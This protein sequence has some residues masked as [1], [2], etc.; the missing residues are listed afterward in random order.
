[1]KKVLFAVLAVTLAGVAPALAQDKPIHVNLGGGVTMPLSDVKDRFGTG[2]HFNIGVVFEP[3][4][5]FGLGVEYSFNRLAGEDKTINVFPTPN[6]G[7]AGTSAT[8]ESHHNMQ[9][10]SFNGMLRPSGD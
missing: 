3:T 6:P 9:Y 8:I 7:A 4:P 10:I 5:T 2:G 1:M